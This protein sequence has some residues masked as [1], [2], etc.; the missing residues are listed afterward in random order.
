M[1]WV[2]EIKF[3]KNEI[4]TVQ[5]WNQEW[6][7]HC[8]WNE[9]YFISFTVADQDASQQLS[10]IH[11]VDGSYQSGSDVS[12]N[13]FCTIYELGDAVLKCFEENCYKKSSTL[14]FVTIQELKDMGFHLGEIAM[15]RAAVDSW[16]V[17]EAW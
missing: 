7:I 4:D 13:E 9:I 10:R 1:P 16:S 11:D 17:S 15:L 8:E 2:N 14:H 12:L 3:V 6:D 5:E